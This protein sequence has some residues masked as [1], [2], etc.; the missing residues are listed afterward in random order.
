[1][2]VSPN[3]FFAYLSTIATGLKGMQVEAR[4]RE[5]LAELGRLQTE[6]GKFEEVF[7][8]VGRHLGNA[9]RKYEEAERLA[10]RVGDRLEAVTERELEPAL[11]VEET[12]RA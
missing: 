10:G 5:I 4:A 9:Q 1:M 6:F 2:P 12:R 3:S 7:R 11:P 8:L